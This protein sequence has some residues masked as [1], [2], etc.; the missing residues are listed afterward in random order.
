L[1]LTGRPPVAYSLP[2]NCTLARPVRASGS[3]PCHWFDPAALVHVS[4]PLPPISAR[5]RRPSR[6]FEE[7]AANGRPSALH[8]ARAVPLQ[9]GMPLVWEGQVIG[10]V[11][12]SGASSA[13]EDQE[14]ATLGA[15][16][17]HGRRP[18]VAHV[19]RDEV[20]FTFRTGGLIVDTP[21]YQVDAGRREGPG[22]VEVHARVT[23]VMHVVQG[24]ATV[25]T[26]GRDEHRIGEGDVLAIPAGITHQFTEVSDPFLYFVVKVGS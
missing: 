12:V 7:Q 16:A 8:L 4:A 10:A 24:S 6:D 2:R 13:P 19:P 17:L 15:D 9:G 23:D 18:V 26:D 5:Y 11:G 22:E 21:G 25:V 1:L 3:V 14:L 20:E